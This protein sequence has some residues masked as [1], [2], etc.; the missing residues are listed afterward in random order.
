MFGRQPAPTEAT[1]PARISPDRIKSAFERHFTKVRPWNRGYRKTSQMK[2]W[3]GAT[4]VA[5]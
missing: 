2:T 5:A 1:V 4:E 3:S